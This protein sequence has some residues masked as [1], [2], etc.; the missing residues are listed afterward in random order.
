MSE[1]N[2]LDNSELP[3]NRSISLTEMSAV[4]ITDNTS[5]V[6]YTEKSS[7]SAVITLS[8]DDEDENKQ[9]KMHD[10]SANSSGRKF[11]QSTITETFKPRANDSIFDAGID[12]DDSPVVRR[13]PAEAKPMLTKLPPP[14]L[15]KTGEQSKAKAEKSAAPPTSPEKHELPE[16]TQPFKPQDWAWEVGFYTNIIHAIVTI[17]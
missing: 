11:R 8:S 13:K 14:K 12:D 7:A 4:S 3:T 5:A 17:L 2:E 9:K 1:G 10:R 6:S 15:T 16:G